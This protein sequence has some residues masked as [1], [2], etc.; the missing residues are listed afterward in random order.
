V[1]DANRALTSEEKRVLERLRT[2]TKAL[3]CIDVVRD[4]FGHSTLRVGKKSF[5][6]VGMGEDREMHMAIK[7]DLVTQ[8]ALIRRG[9]WVRTP[10]IGQHGW[11]SIAIAGRLN[12]AEIED[13]VHD[14]WRSVAPKR[15]VREVEDTKH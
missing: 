7:S 13:L 3:P 2:I 4:G 11:V 1:G 5:V 10:Y 12:W 9:P 15:L 8:D 6:I 14:A